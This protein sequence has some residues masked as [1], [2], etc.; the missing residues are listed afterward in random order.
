MWWGELKIIFSDRECVFQDHS[1]GITLAT[2]RE[3][4]GIYKLRLEKIKKND[5][6]NNKDKGIANYKVVINCNNQN[7][8]GL[9]HEYIKL[10]SK[11]IWYII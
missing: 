7:K 5:A 10:I 6:K 8:L 4:G 3:K 9:E 1:T 11:L 2:E